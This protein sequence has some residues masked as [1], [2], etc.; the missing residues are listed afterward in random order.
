MS[1]VFRKIV[2]LDRRT[3]DDK[4]DTRRLACGHIRIVPKATLH[5]MRSRCAE[6]EVKE[7]MT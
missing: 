7:M 4:H 2:G 3:P 6:C 1:E 5:P